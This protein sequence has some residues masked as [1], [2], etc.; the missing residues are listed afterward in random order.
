MIFIGCE[1]L[2]MYLAEDNK[3][4]KANAGIISKFL[5]AQMIESLMELLISNYNNERE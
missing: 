1:L 2:S 4:L 5:P 3:N